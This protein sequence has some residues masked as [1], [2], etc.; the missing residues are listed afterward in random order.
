MHVHTAWTAEAFTNLGHCFHAVYW[1]IVLNMLGSHLN[2]IL[3]FIPDG[4]N[5]N[6]LSV[7]ADY[8]PAKKHYNTIEAALGIGIETYNPSR[9][10]GSHTLPSSTP[11]CQAM[12][13]SSEKHDTF[14]STFASAANFQRAYL[15]LFWAILLGIPSGDLRF[16]RVMVWRSWKFLANKLKRIHLR[17]ENSE[18]TICS[19]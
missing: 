19:T 3:F 1:N 6:K 4:F 5:Q 15:V 16:N 14:F 17:N 10:P 18:N 8:D 13:L 9:W 7:L 11:P 12:H 2:S